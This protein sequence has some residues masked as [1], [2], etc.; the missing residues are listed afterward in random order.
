MSVRPR[1]TDTDLTRVAT[2]DPRTEPAAIPAITTASVPAK[3]YVDGPPVSAK[4][5]VHT[6]SY[7]SVA[8]PESVRR[9]AASP[10]FGAGAGADPDAAWRSLT[11]P[12]ER[13]PRFFCWLFDAFGDS[14][15]SCGSA[16]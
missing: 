12:R 11:C 2:D 4:I 10:H 8:N 5:L 15:P 1:T 9:I 7:V 6:I 3:A 13:P 14:G 16:S